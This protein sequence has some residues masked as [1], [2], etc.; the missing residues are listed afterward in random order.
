MAEVWTWCRLTR[1]MYKSWP[2][3]LITPQQN[4]PKAISRR[5]SSSSESH[6]ASGA[7][8]CHRSSI[9]GGNVGDAT[10]HASRARF[11]AA[12]NAR[13]RPKMLWPAHSRSDAHANSNGPVR[14]PKR[15]VLSW[16]AN[17]AMWPAKKPSCAN[18]TSHHVVTGS[19]T[20]RETSRVTTWKAQPMLSQLGR[21]RGRGV[22]GG[23]ARAAGAAGKAAARAAAATEAAAAA[24]RQQRSSGTARTNNSATPAASSGTRTRG[25]TAPRARTSCLCCARASRRARRA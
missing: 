3:T 4:R 9:P 19:V 15:N 17:G 23:G 1:R 7:R 2:T 22:L 21:K 25:R 13:P 6:G 11:M 8:T 5:R 10:W 18:C 16:A 14:K 12:A 20:S 24:W